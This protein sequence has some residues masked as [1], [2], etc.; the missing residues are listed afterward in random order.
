MLYSVIIAG[1]SGERLWPLSTPEK[2]KQ[3]LALIDEEPLI[4]NTIWRLKGLVDKENIFIQ[5]TPAYGE[6]IAELL[7]DFKTRLW[8]EPEKKDTGP[9]VALAA[10]RL[11]MHDPASIMIALWSDHFIGKPDVFRSA[12]KEASEI[13]SKTGKLVA[14]GIKPNRPETTLGY[15]ELGEPMVGESNAFQVARFKEKPDQKTA[16]EYLASGKFLWNAGLF[17]WQSKSLLDA[18]AQYAPE[19]YQPLMEIKELVTSGKAW[20]SEEVRTAFAK[21]PKI[22]LDYAVS[23][24]AASEMVAIESDPHWDDIGSWQRLRAILP[25]DEKGNVIRGKVMPLDS[26][27]SIIFNEK[28]G[29]T[30]AAIGTKKLIVVATNDAILIADQDTDPAQ[31]KK[32][33]KKLAES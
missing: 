2:P 5:T 3:L 17:A 25:K 9:A 29:I 4:K 32:I 31:I 28:E 15:I 11:Y 6:K 21:M 27:D 1:G 7:P 8:V 24:K 18:F 20:E 26:E 14:I 12:L 30:V 22:S 13:A 23:E 33:L 19:I 10:L 16:E